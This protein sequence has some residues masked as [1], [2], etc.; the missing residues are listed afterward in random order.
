VKTTK[1]KLL[2]PRE[3]DRQQ[4]TNLTAFS[5]TMMV[6][7]FKSL[8]RQPMRISLDMAL[9]PALRLFSSNWKGRIKKRTWP[10]TWQTRIVSFLKVSATTWRA[11]NSKNISMNSLT[12]YSSTI[13][14]I[15]YLMTSSKT[16]S[17]K[18]NKSRRLSN[19]SFSRQYQI[20]KKIR[21]KYCLL[22]DLVY[23][24]TS[25]GLE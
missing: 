14:L 21:W 22:M 12:T 19:L 3:P 9:A 1:F 20:P 8:W 10:S 18:T 7:K 17:W 24:V 16:E 25:T 15:P 4:L 5:K 11:Q 2:R 13:C 6:K 23:V